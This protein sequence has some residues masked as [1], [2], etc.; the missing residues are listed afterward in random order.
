[1]YESRVS[2]VVEI[3]S[4]SVGT[5]QTNQGGLVW[6]REGRGRRGPKTN[7]WVGEWVLCG[8]IRVVKLCR[9]VKLPLTTARERG[10]ATQHTRHSHTRSRATSL[11]TPGK[12]VCGNERAKGLMTG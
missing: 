8:W 7:G 11:S 12:R 5:E 9:A 2:S 10:A 4:G 6:R 3:C 1:M